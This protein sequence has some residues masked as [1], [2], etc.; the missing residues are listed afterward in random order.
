LH[1]AVL[2]PSYCV[3]GLQGKES[4][5][6]SDLFSFGC[7]LYEVD[8]QARIRG[9]QRHPSCKRFLRNRIV[10]Y[11]IENVDGD[12][13]ALLDWRRNLAGAPAARWA[14]THLC[15]LTSPDSDD[16]WFPI[17]NPRYSQ[18][19]GR[20]LNAKLGAEAQ[21][22]ESRFDIDVPLPDWPARHLLRVRGLT[23]ADH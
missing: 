8:G 3:I 17:Y 16:G 13:V 10:H 21:P 7:V 9:L 1:D 18:D 2:L 5:S 4:D 6:R 23:Q 20:E 14:F 15:S 12:L 22:L 19:E 11:P